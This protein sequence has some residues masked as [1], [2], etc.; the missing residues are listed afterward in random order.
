MN[1]YT[2]LY[3]KHRGQS[4]KT[5]EA[6]SSFGMDLAYKLNDRLEVNLGTSL[7]NVWNDRL[8]AWESPGSAND[9]FSYTSLII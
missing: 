3:G 7:R 6:V 4:N 1:R 9:K 2:L 8:D 5:T